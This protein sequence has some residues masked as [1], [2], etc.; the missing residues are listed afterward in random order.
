MKII[1]FSTLR[2]GT[3]KTTCSLALICKLEKLKK[4][5]LAVDLNAQGDLTNTLAVSMQNGGSFEVLNREK[6]IKDVI[7]RKNEYV[8]VLPFSEKLSVA[9]KF[10]DMIGKE[11]RLKEALEKVKDEYEYCI[12]DTPPTLG[13]I[14]LNA[15]S[16]SDYIVI[17]IKSDDYYS[18]NAIPAI[19]SSIES[20]KKY[21]NPNLKILG[22]VLNEFN[23][24]CSFAKQ[25][26]DA[27]ADAAKSLNTIVFNSKIKK[28]V[29]IAENKALKE[30]IFEKNSS[31]KAIVS[32]DEFTDELVFTIK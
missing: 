31:N 20:V 27:V 5:V 16:A 19:A 23:S 10:L 28:G 26:C 18:L 3:G 17:P 32:L 30:N 29:A 12:I 11:Y 6:N 15:Y 1:T 8:S 7:I 9:D 13:I 2:G 22:F 4:K 24:R 14:V 21:T 25:L